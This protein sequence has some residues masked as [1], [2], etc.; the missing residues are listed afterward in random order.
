MAGPANSGSVG[1]DA[2]RQKRKFAPQASH[3]IAWKILRCLAMQRVLAE[4]APRSL[5]AIMSWTCCLVKL[6]D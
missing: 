3:Q 1:A 5:L 6:E 2:Q 4:H